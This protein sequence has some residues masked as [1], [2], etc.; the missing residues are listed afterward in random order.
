MAHDKSVVPVDASQPPRR[1]PWTAP[2]VTD[3]PR[4][5]ELTLTSG[6]PCG[7]GT[8]GGGTGVCP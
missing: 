6:I 5:T 2:Q 1:S 3:L 8:G 7:G 4:L